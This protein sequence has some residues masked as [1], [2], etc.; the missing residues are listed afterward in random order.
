[1]YLFRAMVRS[2]M[3]LR[4]IGRPKV[5]TGWQSSKSF[6]STTCLLPAVAGSRLKSPLINLW[7]TILHTCKIS[8]CFWRIE[9]RAFETGC[10]PDTCFVSH[11]VHTVPTYFKYAKVTCEHA[12]YIQYYDK[13]RTCSCFI[14]RISHYSIC[15][16]SAVKTSARAKTPRAGVYTSP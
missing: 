2:A 13:Y 3:A 4:Y 8:F 15:Y 5:E 16:N 9:R 6:K 11:L 10:R 12:V 1:M 14:I 7:K